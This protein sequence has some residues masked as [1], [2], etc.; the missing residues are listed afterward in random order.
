M[1]GYRTRTFEWNHSV[2]TELSLLSHIYYVSQRRVYALFCGI[3]YIHAV[4]ILGAAAAA[5]MSCIFTTLLTATTT[6]TTM[7]TETASHD[8]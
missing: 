5:R 3:L 6:T 8:V 4:F 7:M 1:V 2:R